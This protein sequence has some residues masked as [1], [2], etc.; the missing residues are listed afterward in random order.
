MWI[1]IEATDPDSS[2]LGRTRAASGDGFPCHP[3]LSVT[4]IGPA[5]D[6]ITEDFQ[7]QD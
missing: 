6:Y 2:T 3:D 5:R 7:F 1:E 4:W